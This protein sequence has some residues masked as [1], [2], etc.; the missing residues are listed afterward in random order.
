MIC[1]TNKL[2]DAVVLAL[3]A[4]A[5]TTG[6]AY[7]QDAEKGATNLDRIQV[8]GS[9]IRSV[10]AE[11][12][13]PVL[14]LSRE[15]IQQTGRTS[16]A[17]VLQQIAT[18][19]AA[20]NT[21]FNNGGDGSSG[22]DLRNLGSSR[23]LVLVN[24]RRW[25]SALDGSVDL[26]T[27]PSAM[28]ERIE[29]LKDGASSIYGSDAIAG[30]V[31]IITREDFNGGEAHVYRGQFSKGD[32][33][34]EGYDLTLGT[35]SDRGNLVFGASYVKEKAV[36]AGAR[37]ISRDPVYGLGSSQYSGQTADG[38]IWDLTVDGTPTDDMDYW[39]S[40]AGS[41]DKATADRAGIDRWVVNKGADGRNLANYHAYGNADKYNYA[42]DNYLRTPQERKSVYIQGRY[43]LTDSIAL[44]TDALYNQ[45]NSAQQLAGFP[46]SAGSYMD[47]SVGLSKDSYYNPTKGAAD[48]RN[49]NWNRRLVEQERFYEQDVKTLHWYGGLEGS[50]QFADR[51]FNWDAGLSYN[52][53]DQ[54]D[55]QVGDVNMANLYQATGASFMDTDG[56]VKCGSPGAVIEGCVPFNP[57]S[58]AG[59]MPQEMLDYIL[60][61]AKDKF[62]NKSKSFTANLAG[63]IVELPGGMMGFAAGYEHR[64][65]SG[66]DLP[67][68]FV[69]AGMSSGNAR[70]PTSGDYSLDDLYL[71]L[72]IPLLK[73][74]PGAEVLEFS[75]A[76]RYSDYSNFGNT[77][78]SKFG[79]KW[80]PYAD[81]LVRG[82]WAEGFRAPSISNMFGGGSAS[83]E[84]YGDPC[85]SDSP[86]IGNAAVAQRCAAAGISAAYKQREKYG[87]Q[88]PWPFDWVSNQELTPETSTSKTLGLVFSPSFLKGFDVSLDW[89]QI[90]IKN[91]I[92]RPQVTYMLD[93]CYVEGN[94]SW[95]DI[96]ND[97]LTRN[98]LGQITYLKMG[99][100]NLGETE[101]EGYD[102]TM[103]YS[104]P[105][106]R[107]GA[108]SF[109][110]DSTYMSSYRTKAT[111]DADWDASEV[112]TYVKDT[113]VWR[114]RSN[115]TANWTYG[116]FGL[117]WT[118]R[119]FSS[120]VENCKYPTV[121]ALCSDPNR[122]TASGKD[123]QNKLAA[124]TYHDL[125]ARY[126]VPWNATVS[127][128][129]NNVFAKEPPVATQ[130]FANSFDYQYDTPG[131]YYYMEYRQRF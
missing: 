41:K 66:Y 70:Q 71:E 131:R 100:A 81:L 19:G 118:T 11:T 40:I 119:Y 126:N 10:D 77:L 3:V 61:T 67:D 112:G 127:V 101:V 34:R 121:A 92:S 104:L 69:S 78:N 33:E 128:G 120:L 38:G 32:G 4:S 74:L 43:D 57:L 98:A 84:G 17:D 95:C 125:Q 45:R 82:N 117:T 113:P 16:V 122:V 48:A 114:I 56:V 110:W 94:Q 51:Y 13:Q 60:F 15:A 44:R 64:K 31:N 37:K 62:Q 52:S 79:F 102:L 109:I 9:R 96:V 25:V 28:V 24:G 85:S 29:V 26:N 1:K 97:G 111:P 39:D 7:A 27:I 35:S 18:N 91:V 5:G 124:T 107:F 20:I 108:F 116:D 50:F 2:R 90:N 47:G 89:W 36:K 87:D 55:T 106:T 76:T 80:K 105:D 58:S 115:L 6:V 14:T 42:A 22:V 103:R 99:L 129:V 30:V 83:Y 53:N 23:T 123:P 88:T 130:A 65:E 21:Q 73:D 93:Q 72:A 46:L 59:N 8:T 63:D 54:I 86:F 68:A 49:L 75:V 12:S